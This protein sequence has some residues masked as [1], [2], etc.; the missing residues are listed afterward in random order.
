MVDARPSQHRMPARL[1][2][3]IRRRLGTTRLFSRP[4]TQRGVA[5]FW[6][7]PDAFRGWLRCQYPTMGNN[8][9]CEVLPLLNLS[10][11]VPGGSVTVRVLESARSDVRELYEQILAGSYAKPFI[12]EDGK[13][14]QLL[15]SLD[16]IQS[17][18]RIDDPTALDFAYTRKMMAFLLF[19]PNPEHVLMV[20]L[21]GGSLAKFCHQHLP[22]TR[23]TVIEINPDV[24]ALR[25]AFKIPDAARLTIIEADAAVYLP[26]A[27]G[28]TDVLLLDGYDPVGISP[29][30]LNGDF[31]RAARARLR[32]GG[33]LVANLAG[34]E[35]SW[36]AHW[37]LLNEVFEQ[38]VQL[39]RISEED[40]HIAFAFADDDHPADW[41]RLKKPAERLARRIPLD[42]PLLL[43]RLRRSAVK[44]TPSR[45]LLGSLPIKHDTAMQ[46]ILKYMQQSGEQLDAEIAAATRIPLSVVRDHLTTLSAR[47]DVVVC[48]STRFTKGKKTEGMLCR[49]AGFIPAASPGRKSGAKA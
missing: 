10:G 26:E 38:R 19:V 47:G 44:P 16:Y 3:K 11:K 18:M 34:H 28:D 48:R 13:T 31:Y 42:F 9:E 6:R 4:T 5:F 37:A 35:S 8:A 40:N 20:G 24:I 32:P 14:R 21:G 2:Q 30:F 49:I 1:V 41:E 17:S 12:I 39:L 36:V 25:G 29:A 7:V 43:Q 22:C 15:F 46:A 33:M 23:L 27:K 45:F